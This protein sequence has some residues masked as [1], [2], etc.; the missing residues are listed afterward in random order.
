MNEAYD[1]DTRRKRVNSNCFSLC[2]TVSVSILLTSSCAHQTRVVHSAPPQPSVWDR[3]IRNAVD[4]GDGD[5]RLRVLREKAA[6]EPDN[7]AVR[8]DLAKAY[9][10]RGYPDMALELCRMIAVRFP[11]SG[12]AQQIG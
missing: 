10:E 5:Y 2:L 11:D 3:Q 7:I 8:L 12:E 4:A 9:Q 1:T 6:S